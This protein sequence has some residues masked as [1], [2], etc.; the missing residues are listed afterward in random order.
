MRPLP[1][2]LLIAVFLSLPAA[3]LAVDAPPP[4]A[5]RAVP[6]APV[7]PHWNQ[8]NAD[9][10]EALSPLQS[11]WDHLDSTRKRKWLEIAKR[12]KELSPEGKQR[13]HERM[14][15]LAHLSPDERK[16]ARENFQK[17]YALPAN[18]REA[19]TQGFQGLS[20]E[21][22]QKLA[23]DARRDPGPPPRHDNPPAVRGVTAPATGNGALAVQS[24]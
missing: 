17:A 12:Y 7:D 10:K 11:E 3:A 9:Q 20:E 22:K 13:M 14:P 2:C 5:A 15:A 19:K 18:V 8:L 23:S 24:H 1:V 6:P 4:A 16:R 21:Q